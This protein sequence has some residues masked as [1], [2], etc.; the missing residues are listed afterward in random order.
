MRQKLQMTISVIALVVGAVIPWPLAAGQDAAPS[1]LE[2]L[3]AQY[4]SVK[5]GSD[6]NG[7]AV[8]EEGTVL[9]IQKGGLLGVP[10][11]AV[12][13]CPSKYENGSLKTPSFLCTKGKEEA[14][15]RGLGFLK[16]HIPGAGLL[17]DDKT[18]ASDTRYFKAGEK[19][20]PSNIAVDMKKDKISFGVVACDTC[21]QTN[22]PTYY[23]SEVEFQFAKGY[24]E[25]AD[26]SKVEDTIGEVFA[27][28]NSN[29]ATGDQQPAPQPD[30]SAQTQPASIQMGETIDQ[31]V[32]AFG[33]PEKTVNLGLKQ[34][35]VYK[36]L[37]VTFVNGKV[38]DVQ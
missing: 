19:V 31:V 5:M 18:N 9:V 26:A 24:L 33:Q 15:K 1:L 14:G 12:K 23:K 20:Y 4:K 32:T 35:Y 28:D 10:W 27:A 6:S 22:P 7:P 36:D 34:I 2:Q 17:P 29:P 21:N 37:K 16:G 11:G 38:S 30:Q 8:L 25:T 13:A 3:Q